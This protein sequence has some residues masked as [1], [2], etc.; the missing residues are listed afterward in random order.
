MADPADG[1][2]PDSRAKPRLFNCTSAGILLTGNRPEAIE[3]KEPPSSNPID[4]SSVRRAAPLESLA[5]A[6]IVTKPGLVS[7]AS[8]RDCID[9][10]KGASSVAACDWLR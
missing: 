2:Y 10:V 3:P 6:S 7:I 5:V 1:T 9:S 8:L 4:W